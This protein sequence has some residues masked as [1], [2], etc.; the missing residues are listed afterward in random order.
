MASRGFASP[1]DQSL[2]QRGS[3]AERSV[4]SVSMVL[5]VLGWMNHEGFGQ[6]NRVAH[7]AGPDLSAGGNGTGHAK[8][9]PVRVRHTRAFGGRASAGSSPPAVGEAAQVTRSRSTS[10]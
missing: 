10:P 6:A 8:R 4:V 5:G 9:H 2:S 7:L 3:T 1:P